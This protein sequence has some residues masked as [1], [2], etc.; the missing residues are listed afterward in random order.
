LKN[1]GQNRFWFLSAALILGVLVV[2]VCGYL[3][4]TITRES[5]SKVPVQ[6]EKPAPE[7]PLPRMANLPPKKPMIELPPPPSYPPDAPVLEQARNSL[8][9]GISTDEAIALAKSLPESPERADAAFLLLEYA[10]DSGSAE[11][12]MLVA[13]YYDPADDMPSGTIRKNPETAYNWYMEALNGGREEVRQHITN[14]RQWV[15]AQAEQGSVE[16]QQ[17]L[18]VW[19]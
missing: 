3:I 6:A 12:A 18:K 2:V 16:A 8:R 11:A 15:E 14:L 9:E 10:A 7:S 19:R 5:S 4:W 13:R 17:L 1:L